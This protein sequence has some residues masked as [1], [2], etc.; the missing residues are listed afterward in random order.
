MSLF[1]NTRP[2]IFAVA[3][4]AFWLTALSGLPCDAHA[5][6]EAPTGEVI[7]VVGGNISETNVGDEAHFDRQMLT[8]LGME[9]LTTTT[10]FEE[11]PQDFQGPRLAALLKA[12]GAQGQVIVATALDGYTVEIPT[13][14]MLDYPVLL[15]MV[16][17]GKEMGI[18]N[19]G[20]TWIIYP[21]D[22]Y[23][24]LVEEKFSTRSVWQLSSLNI[25]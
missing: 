6:M 3:L 7:L 19:K 15:A 17:N 9:T 4:S 1:S 12:V 22:Q 8:A 18:R 16:W 5:E 25:Q 24:E 10:P 11:T 14:D 2:L 21:L 20:P 23:P 13:R